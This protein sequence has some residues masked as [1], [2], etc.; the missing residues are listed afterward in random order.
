MTA[1]RTLTA[2]LVVC[3]TSAA[4]A[5]AP[6]TDA[7]GDPLPQGVLARL[8]SSRFTHSANVDHIAFSAD[9][10]SVVFVG[11]DSVVGRWNL[12][13]GKEAGRVQLQPYGPRSFLLS[14]DGTTI[15]QARSNQGAVV[16][17][18]ATGKERYTAPRRGTGTPVLG[19]GKNGQTLLMA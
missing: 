16:I 8:G 5:D 13:D 4:L 17:D 15:A 12:A 2:L 1:I 7:D 19:W 11:R 14:P 6:K 18:A 9:G 10:K 3:L